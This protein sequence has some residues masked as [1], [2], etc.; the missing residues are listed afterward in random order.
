MLN[1]PLLA[2]AFAFILLA[3]GLYLAIENTII[4]AFV[5][6]SSSGATPVT[7]FAVAVVA[8]GLEISFA[9]WI[10]Q[11]RTLTAVVGELKHKCIFT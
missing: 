10:R 8:S 3:L 9:S 5:L 2:R 7:A 6:A 1:N 4:S 11:E